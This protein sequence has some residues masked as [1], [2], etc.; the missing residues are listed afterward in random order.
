MGTIITSVANGEIM[1][2]IDRDTADWVHVRYQGKEGYASDKYVVDIV[3]EMTPEPG[4]STG[5]DEP[6]SGVSYHLVRVNTIEPDGKLNLREEPTAQ[7]RVL[8]EV[9]NNA[10]LR[11]ID[12]NF[13]GWAHVERDGVTGYVSDKFV[14]DVN[15]V[16]ALDLPYFIEVDRGQQVVRVYTIAEDGTY[17]LLAREMIC[18]TDTFNRKPPNATYAMDGEKLRWLITLT[19]GSYAQYATRITGHILFHSLPYSALEPDQLNAEAYGQLGTNTSIGCVRLL[20]S[21][22]KWIY[23]NVPAGTPVRYVTGERDEAKLAELAPPPLV[24]GNWDPTDANE[25]NPDYDPT[26]EVTHPFATPVPNVTPAP[27]EPWTPATY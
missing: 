1:E 17:S 6:E 8:M 3:P 12:R 24:S 25:N 2:L 9:E 15:S 23:D 10:V 7:G 27:T 4:Q 20:C 5:E 18:S 19:P 22:A 21:D 26:Y 16:S 13:P 14:I 11:L